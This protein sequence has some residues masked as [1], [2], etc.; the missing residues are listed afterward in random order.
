MLLGWY[1]SSMHSKSTPK[2]KNLRHLLCH[3]CGKGSSYLQDNFPYMSAPWIWGSAQHQRIHQHKIFLF[4]SQRHQSLSKPSSSTPEDL[5]FGCWP[6]FYER[7][8]L[9]AQATSSW[10]RVSCIFNGVPCIALFLVDTMQCLPLSGCSFR[11]ER[12]V[13]LRSVLNSS[14]SQIL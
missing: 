7:A 1:N 9:C 4:W 2:G 11:R 6:L 5:H 13:P 14:S 12:F 10:H 8:H 3:S